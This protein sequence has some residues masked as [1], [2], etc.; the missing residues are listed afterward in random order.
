MS[1]GPLYIGCAGWKLGREYWPDFPVQG[2][3]LERY[4]ARCDA[5]EINSSFYRSHRPSTYAKWAASV[6]PGFRFSV[7]MPKSITHLNRLHDC[8]VLLDTFLAE[9]TALGSNLGCLLIQLP[10]SLAFDAAV[11]GEFFDNL[12]ARYSGHVVIE[13]RHPSWVSAQPMLIAQ[14]IAQAAVDPPRI[15]SD[16]VPGGWDGLRYWRL[17]G[18]PRIYY[19][20]YEAGWLEQLAQGIKEGVNDG[21]PTWCIFDNTARDA[22]LGNA[23]FTQTLLR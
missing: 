18:S 19:S 3:H 11:A 14:Q 10:P 1:A 2:S 15:G 9:C 20:A 12:R 6:N 22:A 7:K 13:P 16:A 8:S 17:H 21:V 23:L 5:V 4:S